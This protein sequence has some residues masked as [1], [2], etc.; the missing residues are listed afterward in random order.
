[1]FRR[2]IALLLCGFSTALA[3]PTAPPDPAVWNVHVRYQIFA[4]R[5]ERLRQYA[6][7]AAVLKAARFER[8]PDEEVAENEPE[9]PRATRLRG[10]VPAVSV[11]RLLGQRHIRSLLLYPK[12]TT[13]PAKGTRVRV[14]LRL[15]SGY[16][17][18]VQR[19]LATQTAAVLT[20]D[21]GLVEA[22]GYDRAGDTR[23]LGSVPAE[24]LDRLLEDIRHLPTAPEQGQPLMSVPAVRV[25]YARP[26]WP[27]PTGRPK[28]A[29]IAEPQRKF[30]PELRALLADA[31]AA[32]KQTR[33]EV[34]LGWTPAD[35][36]RE[37]RKILA[38]EG[39]A[40]EG[41][42]GPLVGVTGV[43]GAIAPLLAA[44][45]EVLAVRL[46]RLGRTGVPGAPSEPPA[47]WEALR[48][49]GLTQIHDRGRRGKG[50]RL[51]VIADDFAGWEALRGRREGGKALPDPLLFDLT[52]ERNRDLRPDAY[53]TAAG[54]EGHGTRCARALMKAAPEAEVTLVRLDAAAP[55]MLQTVARAINGSTVATI[56]LEDRVEELRGDR[57]RLD[58]RRE[59]LLAERER[60]NALVLEDEET[61]K[62]RQTYQAQQAAFDADELAYRGRLARYFDLARGLRALH[63]IRVVASTLVW[64]D[65][66][67]VDGSSALSRLFDDRPF[68]AALWFQAA[69]DSGGQAWTGLFRDSDGNGVMEFAGERKMLP[70]DAWSAELNFLGWRGANSLAVRELPAGAR[71]RLSLQWR[72]AH[73]PLPLREGDDVY[74]KPLSRFRLVVVNQ[75]DPD[76][77][78]RPADDLEVV[79]QTTGEPIRLNQTA[80]A[81]TYEVTVELSVARGGRYAVFVEGQAPDSIY[82]PGENV[83]PAQRR[84]GEVHPRL[85]VQTLQGAGR[86]VWADFATKIAALGTPADARAVIT[87][88]AADETGTIRPSSAA[89]GPAGLALLVKPD[90]L[91]FDEGGG[92]GQ[93][94]S[95]AAGLAAAAWPLTGTLLGV[96]ERLQERPGRLLRVGG[97]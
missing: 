51:A 55:Y 34:I 47:K 56:S 11:N 94:A 71:L 59:E 33:L 17:P 53:P 35:N 20:R 80:N 87:V 3:L 37:W 23:L 4:F 13:L 54:G 24:Y 60:V 73:D 19:R 28:V 91:A 43:P 63:G 25:I 38:V 36:D 82:A 29:D 45:D 12:D 40:I 14:D 31:A 1:M 61:V 15:V 44:R 93:A 65:G 96:V 46:P 58:R 79:A 57:V 78:A 27:V 85:F 30:A 69:G 48:A 83:L 72:E 67:P 70:A 92:S 81:A 77:R 6:E 2:V 32:G 9:N 22:V 86:A 5:T 39:M 90:A 16:L 66:F 52:A 10:T 88:A 84:G 68:R 50:M 49:S 89:G 74:R 95:F 62:Q 76:G 8:D 41:R 18:E 26:D 97:R 21:A 64:T 75:L 7:M 42:V